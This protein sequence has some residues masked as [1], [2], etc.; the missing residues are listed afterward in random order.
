MFCNVFKR[1]F[2]GSDGSSTEKTFSRFTVDVETGA[3]LVDP[4]TLDYELTTSH[5]I[6]INASSDRVSASFRSHEWRVV[7]EV[8]DINDHSL[9]FTQSV[10]SVGK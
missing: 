7:I 10:V 6:C 4:K 1:L 9:I 5:V 3:I 2:E 8:E